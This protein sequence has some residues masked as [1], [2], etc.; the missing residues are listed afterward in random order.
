M[1]P[2]KPRLS[3]GSAGFMQETEIG[4]M[5]ITYPFHPSKP[6]ST[7]AHDLVTSIKYKLVTKCNKNTQ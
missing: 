5:D 4:K 1:Y 2:R 6:P 7:K 3:H